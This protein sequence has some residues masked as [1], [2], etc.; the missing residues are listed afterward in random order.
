MI[1]Y[2]PGTFH[3][4]QVVGIRE[5]N[6]RKYI[7]L[8]DGYKE[9]YR[10][11][12]NDFQLE[13][14]DYNIPDK[15]VCFVKE[16]S[17]NGLPFL[18]QSKKELLEF[19]YSDVGSEYPFKVLNVAVDGKTNAPY[20]TLNDSFGIYHRY[21]PKPNEP[22]HQI[23]DI[24]NLVVEG[25]NV[26]EYNKSF[27]NFEYPHD[28]IQNITVSTT[29]EISEDPR[30][31]SLFGF[32]SSSKEFKSTIV[33]PAGSIQVDIDKQLSYILKTIAGFQN[34][35]GGEL[36][37][38]ID[39]SGKI[40]GINQD[41]VHLNSS[42]TDNYTYQLNTDGYENKIRSAVR[43][44]IGGTSNSHLNFNFQLSS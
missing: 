2:I 8:S 39:D 28:L 35:E 42:Q 21:Y 27:L 36:Y 16:I 29:S 22:Q 24:F 41:Y 5:E 30:T 32:E 15:I 43:Y 13:W 19:C 10:V 20:Y 18:E 17:I 38:G 6:D 4:F 23:G 44:G 1:T 31:E 33:Y 26:R 25:I 34:A 40:R 12:P 37:I 7:Y 3:T 14:E 9:T 11:K